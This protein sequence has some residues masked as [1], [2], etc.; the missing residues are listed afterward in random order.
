MK[1]GLVFQRED[2]T[3]SLFNE[4]LPL[5]R[6]HYKEIAR[7]QDIPL[8]VDIDQYVA[9]DKAGVIRCYTARGEGELIGYSNYFVRA[10]PHF[11]SSIQALSDILYIAPSH[12]GFGKSFLLWC[13]QQLRNE[14]IQEVYQSVTTQ[15]EFGSLL[16]RIGY[17]RI[18]STY[19]KRL[20]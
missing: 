4:A 3:H 15:Y 19:T 20:D 10:H 8:D 17:I 2:I 1:D 13:E 12:R 9:L 18:D 11:K 6:E 7:F 5:L 14:H 16:E